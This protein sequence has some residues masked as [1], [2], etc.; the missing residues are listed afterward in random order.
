MALEWEFNEE[1]GF[2]ENEGEDES[3]W[4]KSENF[5]DDIPDDLVEKFIWPKLLLP[6][7]QDDTGKYL[8]TLTRAE[9]REHI[10][11]MLK[12]K[13]VCRGWRRWVGAQEDWVYGVCNYIELYL[14]DE[15]CFISEDEDYD[16]DREPSC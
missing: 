5:L 8:R 3:G 2:I 6:P 4:R 11:I 10:R 1:L 15:W 13:G 12:L 9:H 7:L 14:I 16:S